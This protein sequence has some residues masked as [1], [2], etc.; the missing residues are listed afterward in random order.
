VERRRRANGDARD[1]S[2]SVRSFHVNTGMSHPTV[3]AHT[4]AHAVFR[5]FCGSAQDPK[6]PRLAT[7]HSCGNSCSRHRICGHPCP[8]PCHPGP[9]PP[10]LITIQ[11]PCHC[12]KDIV[13][14]VCSRANPTT[15]GTVSLPA[16]RS[17]GHECGKPLSCRNHF[18]R[19]VCHDGE[20][21][22]CSV[23]D[24]SRCW[25]GKERKELAC[26]EG[27]DK[28]CTILT[29]DGKESWIGRFRCDNTCERSVSSFFLSCLAL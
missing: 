21:N 27:E 17:C 26:G 13:A 28:E 25:C 4:W 8:L 1:V 7:P 19:D 18:C 15:G 10:C 2:L 6:P 3:R 24:L 20:C 29:G 12:G 14:L 11:N 5:C 23:T 16:S 22:P 9:C